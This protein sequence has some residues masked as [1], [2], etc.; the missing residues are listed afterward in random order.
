MREQT[1]RPH[2]DRIGGA[3]AFP[4]LVADH[5][6]DP[7]LLVTDTGVIRWATPSAGPAFGRPSDWS[8]VGERVT[9]V[10]GGAYDPGRVHA[11]ASDAR[12]TTTDVTGE[13]RT[14]RLTIAPAGDGYY[15]YV[16]R[17]VTNLVDAAATADAERARFRAVFD[18][19]LDALVLADDDG[20][21]V[22][23]NPAACE[24]FGLSRAAL[25]GKSIAAFAPP[26]FDFDA[27]WA[28]FL[29]AGEQSGTFTLRRADGERRV[30]EFSAVADVRPHEHLA[31]LRDVTDRE[32]DRRT[33]E[34]QRD[35]LA[36]LVDL[37][38]LLRGVTRQVSNRTTPSETLDA[39]CLAF[40]AAPHYEF[41]VVVS[42]FGDVLARAGLSPDDVDDVVPRV[43]T[44]RRGDGD[45]FP[46]VGRVEWPNAP[47]SVAA[48]YAVSMSREA[49]T[50]TLVLGCGVD[51]LTDRERDVLAEIG[52]MVGQVLAG[53]EARRL[54]AADRVVRLQFRFDDP[55]LLYSRVSLETGAVVS[56][57]EV[58]PADA[59]RAIHYVTV[60]ETPAEVAVDAA[61][62]LDGVERVRSV[63]DDGGHTT[64]ELVVS[65]G[66][67]VRSL[68]ELGAHVRSVTA[69]AGRC[70]VVVEVLPGDNVKHFASAVKSRYPSASVVRKRTLS[71]QES[72]PWNASGDDV[73]SRQR[74]VLRAAYSAGYYDWPRR[75]TTGT[76]LADTF[77]VSSA[78]LHQHLRVGEGKVVGAYLR[79][80]DRLET[81][82][83]DRGDEPGG[84]GRGGRSAT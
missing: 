32:A 18:G 29:D 37:D 52:Q 82:P 11:V 64:L 62:S 14:F 78:T 43:E 4:S 50:G 57:A 77:G 65:G 81:E 27:A 30:V 19:A 44:D 72:A 41:A 33:L 3:E 79:A 15:L 58:V 22:D 38:D 84:N 76:E 23:A 21:Y 47:A 73:T 7:V 20:R 28:S 16:A 55:D 74:A 35:E 10:L 5:L 1:E 83:G 17:D 25:L 60:G 31:V 6:P 63:S 54:L 80:A 69:D 24:L 13:T 68:A 48:V 59:G 75:R 61:S 12:L 67:P 8:L 70:D 36:R 53:Q 51:R 9:A 34:R 71:R 66:T 46:A 42:A 39:V 56:V 2:E 45:A 40:V 26:A 49:P